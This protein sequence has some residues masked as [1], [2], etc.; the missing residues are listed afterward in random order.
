[1]RQ[2]VDYKHH[3]GVHCAS[4]ALRNVL[5]HHTGE[6]WSESLCFGLAA[7]L[8]FTY[9]R[10]FN[11]PFFLVMGRG[12]FMESHFCDSLEVQLE[13]THSDDPEIAWQHLKKQVQDGVLMM[14]DADM[15]ELPYMVQRLNL[16]DGVH[17]GGHKALVTGYDAHTDQVQLA[18]YAW[19][20]RKQISVAQLKAARD[21]RICPSRPRNAGFRFHFP[22]TLPPLTRALRTALYTMVNQ[23]RHPFRQFNGLPAISR[24]CRQVP[25]WHLSMRGE[26][27]QLNTS[28]CAF[29]LEKAGTGGGGFRNLYS[30]FLQEASE[31]L[32]SQSLAQAAAVYRSLAVQWREVAALLEVASEHP[33][34]GMFAPGEHARKLMIEIDAAENQ[35]V[36]L[37]EHYLAHDQQA[38]NDTANGAGFAVRSISHAHSE[39]SATHATTR[40]LNSQITKAV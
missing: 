20:E 39:L 37:I 15:F 27:L 23:M 13:P 14:I 9:V 19:H 12:S 18:D 21:S 36:A 35:G 32:Q 1:M 8:N 4:A 22:S 17:F 16:M 24:F 2:L 30:R 26:E 7:G 3:L 25:K 10:E 5:F 11:A 28:L 29:M 38:V 6:R 33:N 31:L 34:Q 40:A